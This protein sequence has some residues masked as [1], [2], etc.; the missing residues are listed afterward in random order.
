MLTRTIVELQ[1]LPP[2]YD[3]FL[4]QPDIDQTKIE[5]AELFSMW[6]V[7]WIQKFFD[8]RIVI[9]A[10]S[11]Q[12]VR[13]QDYF[14]AI[15]SLKQIKDLAGETL[16]EFH[17]EGCLIKAV[18]VHARF[19]LCTLESYPYEAHFEKIPALLE[20]YA[21]ENGEI[22]IDKHLDVISPITVGQQVIAISP[23]ETA[24][25]DAIEELYNNTLS[26]TIS[27]N[28]KK[29]YHQ[30]MVRKADDFL[31]NFGKG[32]F[33]PDALFQ[34]GYALFRLGKYPEAIETFKRFIDRYPFHHSVKGANE[35]ISKAEE[36]LLS[37]R[38]PKAPKEKKTP[39]GMK[40][41]A[42][43][44]QK[45]D[46]P[47][48]GEGTQAARPVRILFLAAN[49]KDTLPLRL[50]E[51]VKAIDDAL[52]QRSEF[53]DRFELVQQWAVGVSDLQ[54]HLLRYNPDIVHFS[55]HGSASNEIILE[56]TFGNS[57]PVSTRA[58]SQLFAILKG[59][60][61]CVVLNACYSEAQAQA[62]AEHIDC[63]IGMSQAIGDVA[64]LNFAKSFYQA[65][66]Y[67]RDIHT[68]YLLGLSQI[69]LDGLED[70]D[71]PRLLNP[72]GNAG[73]MVFVKKD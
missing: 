24:G 63:V 48:P 61:R 50:D 45:K 59:N 71:K 2:G 4:E 51:E 42:G 69:D 3:A 62:I 43:A 66:G 1:N 67:A 36:I 30:E 5:P 15:Q 64:S 68:A 56:D 65:L 8:V 10:G 57:Q 29:F 11:E 18:E 44:S 46:Q 6:L 40:N 21:D 20:Q 23:E 22:D 12:K 27:E 39:S 16:G 38:A 13:S 31:L 53:R 55:G 14:V 47:G 26:E 37:R 25:R 7:N 9:D 70:Q 72:K 41:S 19:S 54:G 49:P 35:W 58:L 28:A 73:Q 33:A 32:Y 34:K 52:L 60:I 17:E